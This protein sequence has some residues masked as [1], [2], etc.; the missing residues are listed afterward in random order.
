MLHRGDATRRPS[1]DTLH[2]ELN[3]VMRVGGRLP[4]SPSKATVHTN[5]NTI[6]KRLAAWNSVVWEMSDAEEPSVDVKGDFE[7]DR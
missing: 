1:I 2:K 6:R 4:H 7:V 5:T 3:P